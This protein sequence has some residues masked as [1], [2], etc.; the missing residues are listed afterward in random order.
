MKKNY[1]YMLLAV[2]LM[3]TSCRNSVPEA[4]A[5]PDDAIKIVASIA[6]RTRAPQYTDDGSG[7]FSQGDRMSLFIADEDENRTSVNYEYGSGILTWGSLGLEGSSA[8]VALAACYPSQAVTRSGTFEFNPLTAS[9][10]DLLLASA[11]TVTA[12]TS[13]AVNLV[14]NHALHR[15]DLNFTPGNSYTDEDMKS[16]SIRLQAKTTCVVDMMQGKIVGVKEDTGEYV[17]KETAASFYLVPQATTGI[18]MNITV[19][20]NTKS[21][22]LSELL[23]QLSASQPDLSS[24]KFSKL[25]LKVSQQ[26]IMVEGGSINA[27][28]NQVTADGEVVIG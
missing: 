7:N 24:G 4:P 20:E 8:K 26:G 16:F 12:G 19:G 2:S 21:L 27:W 14:F 25:T 6:S 9:E 15:L 11:Q 17:S 18:V 5:A 10:A 22:T 28:D 3:T 13:E 1:F 23:D